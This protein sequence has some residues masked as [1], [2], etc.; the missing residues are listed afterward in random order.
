M[1]VGVVV[2][3]AGSGRRLGSAVPKAFVCVGSHP[4]LWY[5]VSAAVS[6]AHVAI[7]VVVAPPTHVR[8]ATEVAVPVAAAHGIPL[9]VRPGGI[10]RGD[11]VLAG[12]QALPADVDLVLV[13]DAA[14]AFTPPE[15]FDRVVAALRLGADAVVP[16]IPVV[17]TVK[18]VDATGVVVATPDRHSLRAVQ[19]P[20][21]FRRQVL[22]DAHRAHGSAATD[23]A[24]LVERSG[25]R[26]VVVPG[27]PR[28]A[29]VTT[30]ED[31]ERVTSWVTGW[32][33]S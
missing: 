19:T 15:V 5:A 21:G 3:A 7:V 16:G 9:L 23:D 13:H 8:E 24:T 1:T 32:V 12:V 4:L 11:S 26:V 25:G 14:R 22:L 2:V 33:T 18:Q 17:D 28:A 20:Q 30:P 6:A 27:D 29:K 10:E 31:L